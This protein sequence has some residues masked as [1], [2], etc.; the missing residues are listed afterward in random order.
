MAA[1][2][3]IPESHATPTKGALVRIDH[4]PLVVHDL[5]DVAAAYRRLG[6]T[7]K[8]GRVH[9]DGI[10]NVHVKFA[11]GTGIELITAVAP[12][13]DLPRTRRRN[14]VGTRTPRTPR[15]E[16]GSQAAIRRR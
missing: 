3:G 1:G 2:S 4:I 11:N 16:S 8:P 9:A 13:D 6:F 5:E 10:R 14:T 15:S 12:T 7:F